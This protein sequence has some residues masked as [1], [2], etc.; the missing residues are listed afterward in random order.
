MGAGIALKNLDRLLY[1]RDERA[2]PAALRLGGAALQSA[3]SLATWSQQRDALGEQLCEPSTSGRAGGSA[4]GLLLLDAPHHVRRIFNFAGQADVAKRY[5]E[6]KLLGYSPRQMYDVVSAVEHY[7]EFVP[8]C[9]R[10]TV[11]LR[12]PP[13]YLEA[14]L[15]VGFQMFVER[16]TSKVTMHCPTLVRSSVEDSTLFSHLSN[17]HI[18]SVFFEEVVQRMMGAFEGRCARLYGPSSLH[19]RAA[20]PAAAGHQQY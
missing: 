17:Q 2:W 11:T 19:R 7:H 18:A 15:E 16:Y 1:S 5:S 8:W 10:S 9:Q 12:R 13:S 6:K 3:A 14:E 4:A 20:G